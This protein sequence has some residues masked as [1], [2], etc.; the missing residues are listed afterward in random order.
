MLLQKTTYNT[1]AIWQPD[2]YTGLVKPLVLST[3]TG[4]ENFFNLDEPPISTVQVQSINRQIFSYQKP[5]LIQGSCTFNV[6]SSGL[7]AVREILQK[8]ETKGIAYSGT[9]IIISLGALIYTQYENMVFTTSFT[10]ASIN[11][12]YGD[13]YIRFSS[14]PPKQ[15]SLGSV[16]SV[17]TSLSG[18]GIL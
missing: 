5:T 15:V 2:K 12:T 3:G 18:A 7:V 13:V 11:K 16:A 10:G 9:G 1:I 4:I 17:F 8:Q 14:K 6:A